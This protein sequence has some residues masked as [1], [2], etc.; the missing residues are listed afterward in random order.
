MPLCSVSS[1]PW[2]IKSRG[3]V[4]SSLW[5]C[6]RALSSPLGQRWQNS[7][8]TPLWQ[9]LWCQNHAQGLQASGCLRIGCKPCKA[10]HIRSISFHIFI[11]FIHFILALCPR[12]GLVR[13]K[14]LDAAQTRPWPVGQFHVLRG[15][16][17]C[18]L[19]TSHGT[20]WISPAT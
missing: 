2:S 16:E 20:T 15:H 10:D 13:P 12:W 7:Q 4:F 9:P 3:T 17:R 19:E 18:V 5:R 6:C 14:V 1:I 8:S 11:H